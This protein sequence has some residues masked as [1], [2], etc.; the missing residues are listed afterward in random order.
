MNPYE[1]KRVRNAQFYVKAALQLMSKAQ[2]RHLTHRERNHVDFCVSLLIASASEE[3]D[4]IGDPFKP[5][6]EVFDIPF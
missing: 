4:V 2:T 6:D 1:L 5:S 3:L